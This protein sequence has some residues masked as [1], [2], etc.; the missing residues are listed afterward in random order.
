MVHFKI[1]IVLELDPMLTI[2]IQ[3]GYLDFVSGS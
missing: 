1:E 3:S 2:C